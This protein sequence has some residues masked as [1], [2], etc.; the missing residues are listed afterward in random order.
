MTP[1]LRNHVFMSLTGTVSSSCR[2]SAWLSEQYITAAV[3]ICLIWSLIIPFC[4]KQVMNFTA[5]ILSTHMVKDIQQWNMKCVRSR[6]MVY[7]FFIK[8]LPNFQARDLL[9]KVKSDV[10][11]Y[12]QV[13]TVLSKWLVVFLPFVPKAKSM[14][15]WTHFICSVFHLWQFFTQFLN[16]IPFWPLKMRTKHIALH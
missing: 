11:N 14:N 5:I 2:T 16:P 4:R 13:L 3:F 15:V 10:S 8:S 1:G 12:F 6:G 7:F 9:W